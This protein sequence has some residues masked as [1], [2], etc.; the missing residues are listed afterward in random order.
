MDIRCVLHHHELLNLAAVELVLRNGR[1]RILQKRRLELGFRPGARHQ[2]GAA[3]RPNAF[4]VHGND[5]VHGAGVEQ[6]FI[7]QQGLEG[8]GAQ[9]LVIDFAHYSFSALR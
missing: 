5:V 2:R 9:R 8:L 3:H 4:V 6:A 7:D 1:A